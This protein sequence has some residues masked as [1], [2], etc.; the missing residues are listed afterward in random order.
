M[1]LGCGEMGSSALS[2]LVKYSDAD[3]VA[4]DIN[5]EKVKKLAKQLG[6]ERVSAQRVDVN[7][8]EGLVKAIKT[9]NPDVVASCIGP[10]YK[11][12]SKVYRAALETSVSCVDL[13]DDYVAAKEA[14]ALNDEAKEAGITIITGVGD[15]PG[16][17]NLIAKYLADKLDKVDN[18]NLYW[19][20]SR[21]EF[22]GSAVIQHALSIYEHPHQY[23]NGK[24]V[25]AKGELVVDF[26]PPVGRQKVRYCDHPEPYTLPLYIKGVKNVI[27]A[28]GNWPSL[29]A[30][31][32]L[33]VSGANL[34]LT[35]QELIKVGKVSITPIEFLTAFI[36][37]ASRKARKTIEKKG[38]PAMGGM[39]I[40]VKGERRGGPTEY[41]F[42]GIGKMAEGTPRSLT[43]VA[44]LL[45]IGEIK[46]KGAYPPEGCIDPELFIKEYSGG[47]LAFKEKGY[48]YYLELMRV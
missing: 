6:A 44:K 18:I 9:A 29:P 4:A 46:V 24:L 37:D 45:A 27:C 25:E 39:R 10:F 15:S 43:T 11:H 26:A 42:L 21:A 35:S 34:G 1:V 23:L 14:L 13:C 7:D 20:V 19:M 48:G 12:A 40:E 3:V 31:D 28:G 2:Q 22:L 41:V 36:L 32:E 8:H 38:I 30:L 47:K 17:T 16:L 33:E 5:L